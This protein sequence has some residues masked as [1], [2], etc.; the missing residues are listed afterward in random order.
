MFTTPC[1]KKPQSKMVVASKRLHSLLVWLHMISPMLPW[2]DLPW[3]ENGCCSFRQYFQEHRTSLFG[4]S[5]RERE[6]VFFALSRD[7][8]GNGDGDTVSDT[9]SKNKS[10]L[11]PSLLMYVRSLFISVFP[12]RQADLF[13]IAGATNIT[14][15]D[16]KQSS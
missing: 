3:S 7:G 4:D 13:S 1:S 10:V 16:F 5:F 14:G 8:N 9:L 11:F 12:H 15:T 6:C 2:F